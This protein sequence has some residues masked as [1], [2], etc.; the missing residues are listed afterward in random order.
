MELEMHFISNDKAARS[1]AVQDS[2]HFN[3]QCLVTLAKKG[4]HLVSMITVFEK[5]FG[6]MGNGLV[7][8]ST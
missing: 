2:K 5:G 7:K 4:E 6:L 1:N 3:S 8:L